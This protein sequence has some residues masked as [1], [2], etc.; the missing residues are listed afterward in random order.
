MRLKLW[1]LAAACLMF[2]ASDLNAQTRTKTK[3]TR[4][5]TK[6]VHKDPSKPTAVAATQT[7]DMVS[8]RMESAESHEANVS[9]PSPSWGLSQGYL[10][11]RLVYFPDFF[12]F[13]TPSRGYIY[14]DAGAWNNSFSIPVFLKG[15]DLRKARTEILD[16]PEDGK[17]EKKFAAY[18]EEYPAEAVPFTIPVPEE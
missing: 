5:V 17:P 15:A 14:W 18:S 10:N 4:T 1:M 3:T 16:E 13:Y 12:V 2:A 7:A 9:A 8:L 11:D 6:S